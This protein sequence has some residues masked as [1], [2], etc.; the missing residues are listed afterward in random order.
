MDRRRFLSTSVPAVAASLGLSGCWGEDVTP[1]TPLPALDFITRD[2]KFTDYRPAVDATG[3]L[4]I[5]ERTPVPEAGVPTKLYLAT[6]I[7]KPNPPV[8]EFLKVPA[9]P[10]PPFPFLQTRPDWSWVNNE[11]AFAGAPTANNALEVH[12]VAA[13]GI[14]SRLVANTFRCIYPMWSSDGTRLV[15]YNENPL[16]AGPYPPVAALIDPQGNVILANL[17]GKDANGIDMFQGFA[18]PMPGNPAMIAFAGQPAL[19]SWGITGTV[20]PGTQ[21]AYNQDNN[22]VFLNAVA[23]GAYRSAPMEP[24]ASITTYDPAHQG[25]ASYWSPDGRYVVF[26]SN[27]AGG[28]ALFLADVAAVQKGAAP[29]RLT[30]PAFAAQHGKFLP[31]GKAIVLTALQQPN[32]AGLGPRGIAIIDI[33]KFVS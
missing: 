31:G 1:S 17:G 9:N 12:V 22:Y 24:A 28:Y 4:C 33:S 8:T 21:P 26:E 11:I 10:P 16:T 2:P 5:F 14:G 25:R 30:D 6:G 20:P 27:R 15:V 7:D 32:A 29:V 23:N 19:A 18:G 3:T 13:T